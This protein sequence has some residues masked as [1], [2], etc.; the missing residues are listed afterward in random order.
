VTVDVRPAHRQLRYGELDR[1]VVVAGLLALARRVGVE[2]VTMRELARELGTS[3]PAVYYHVPNKQ[4]ALD[5]VAATVLDQVEVPTAGTWQER[6]TALYTRGREALLPVPGIATL[7]Q[8]RPLTESGRRL[9]QAARAILRDAGLDA[10]TAGAAH[11]VLYT[12][13]LGSVGLQHA[14]AGTPAARSE[15]SEASRFGYGLRVLVSGIR[16]ESG[17]A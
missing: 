2:H 1:D 13:L 10:R 16:T 14:L 9:D 17:L 4:V 7:L 12:H 3:A 15:R 11:G 5:L 8:T 6:L